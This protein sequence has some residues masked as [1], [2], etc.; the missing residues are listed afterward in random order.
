MCV[1]LGMHARVCVCG[2]TGVKLKEQRERVSSVFCTLC[3]RR[4]QSGSIHHYNM[5]SWESRGWGQ[6]ASQECV[7][8]CLYV[9]FFVGVGG[10]PTVQERDKVGGKKWVEGRVGLMP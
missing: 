5:L 6:P 8:V 3:N 1:D 9:W 7:C 4:S 10:S 2:R